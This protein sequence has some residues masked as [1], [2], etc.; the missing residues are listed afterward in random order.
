MN[1]L[2]LYKSKWGTTKLYAD[3]IHEAYP[4]SE[5]LNIDDFDPKNLANYEKIIIGSRTYM[6]RIQIGKFLVGNWN[7]LKD[8]SVY[9]FSVGLIHPEKKESKQSYEM[10]PEDIR[11]SLSGYIKLPGKVDSGKLN[12]LERSIAKKHKNQPEKVNKEVIRP[13]IDF[14]NSDSG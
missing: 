13:I 12:F 7:I 2:I 5:I 4:E 6:G 14:L 3:W 10:I 1:T 8:K 9:L 11:N